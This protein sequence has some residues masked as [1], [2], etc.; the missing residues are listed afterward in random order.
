MQRLGI[1][2]WTLA[3]FGGCCRRHLVGEDVGVKQCQVKSSG[4]LYLKHVR[5]HEFLLVRELGGGTTEVRCES[6]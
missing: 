5:G 4:S 1:C 2:W 3:V 6:R